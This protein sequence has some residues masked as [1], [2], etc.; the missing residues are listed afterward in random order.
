MQEQQNQPLLQESSRRN[1][2]IFPNPIQ[3]PIVTNGKK[4]SVDEY[5][6]KDLQMTQGVIQHGGFVPGY[7][8]WANRDESQ[9]SGTAKR[10][11][12]EDRVD[13][14]LYIQSQR[15]K[16]ESVLHGL[17]STELSFTTLN[18]IC[19]SAPLA[20]T[21]PSLRIPS[22]ASARS[23]S[24]VEGSIASQRSSPV[25]FGDGYELN[26]RSA[27]FSTERHPLSPVVQQIVF[28]VNDTRV[29]VVQHAGFHPHFAHLQQMESATASLRVNEDYNELCGLC[30]VQRA[31]VPMGGCEHRIC[32]V[33]YRHEKHRSLR[34]F[35]DA[36]PSCPFCAHGVAPTTSTTRVSDN[37][38]NIPSGADSLRQQRHFSLP[39]L[40]QQSCASQQSQHQFGDNLQKS[41]CQGR[42]SFDNS[43]A[44]EVGDGNCYNRQLCQTF[45][46][47]GVSPNAMRLRNPLGQLEN[48]SA[49][50]H[51]ES[52]DNGNMALGGGT[53]YLSHIFQVPPQGSY[54]KLPPG[55]FSAQA[56]V[57]GPNIQWQLRSYQQH[58]LRP[59]GMNQHAP[60]FHPAGMPGA[61]QANNSNFAATGRPGTSNSPSIW[62]EGLVSPDSS[63]QGSM[64]FQQQKMQT[65]IQH[66]Q[67]QQRRAGHHHIFQSSIGLSGH[68]GNSYYSEG[69]NS[70]D[71]NGMNM[72]TSETL[73]FPILPN[74]PPAIPPPTP[75]TEVIK[76]AVVRVTNIPW[77]VSLHDML[78]FFS[79][80]PYPPEHLLPQNVHILMDRA[81]GKTYHSAF[82]ELALSNHQAGMVAQ[83]RNM[84]VLKGRVVTVELSS[85]DELMRSIFPKWAGEFAYGEPMM[86]GENP[87]PSKTV[88][89]NAESNQE[90]T[91]DRA[92]DGDEGIKEA[93]IKAFDGMQDQGLNS[94]PSALQH[95]GRSVLSTGSHG[96]GLST[97]GPVDSISGA[98]E[99][100]TLRFTPPFVARDEI[101]ALLAICR[102][103]KLHF[104]RKCAER[105]FENILSILAKYPW[106]LPHRILPL[107]RD[108]IFELLKLSI[109]SLRT[110]LSKDYNTIN[111][112]LLNRMVRSAIL[113]PA[114]TE[115]QKLMVLHV[116]SCQCPDDIVGWMAPPAPV[117]V[118][119]D[120]AAHEIESGSS[121]AVEA[122]EEDLE[123]KALL[124]ES[125]SQP[126]V[127]T[128][129]LVEDLAISTENA[130]KSTLDVATRLERDEQERFPLSI[131]PTASSSKSSGPPTPSPDNVE[132]KEPKSNATVSWASI[133]TPAVTGLAAT[134]LL[135]VNTTAAAAT[136][137]NTGAMVDAEAHHLTLAP[138]YAAAVVQNAS[139]L[140]NYKEF[141]TMKTPP[142]SGR[143]SDDVMLPRS[144]NCISKH[145]NGPQHRHPSPSF[146]ISKLSSFTPPNTEYPDEEASIRS[147]KF[148]GNS[149]DKLNSPT[150]QRKPEDLGAGPRQQPNVTNDTA[151]SDTRSDNGM[152]SHYRMQKNTLPRGGRHSKL[153]TDSPSETSSKTSTTNNGSPLPSLQLSPISS[154]TTVVSSSDMASS[155]PRVDAEEK[156]KSETILDAIKTI[157]QSTPRLPKPSSLNYMNGLT[158]ESPL[159]STALGHQRREGG[160]TL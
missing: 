99:V 79:G 134:R 9:S 137:P 12:G 38:P 21:N 10:E 96:E 115:K 16:S 112:T 22:V 147:E 27:S 83:A 148:K 92:V 71:C 24:P 65:Q 18:S 19:Q 94:K 74:L 76:W 102:N 86:P 98:F 61:Q 4:M 100:P 155:L 150:E 159:C 62:H 35:Q 128:E 138:S 72:N 156:S 47:H 45:S 111:P 15:R 141:L 5:H 31:T 75:R 41:S 151:T 28:G 84:K 64:R 33:C 23:T 132:D 114:F 160:E 11:T 130:T 103:Y 57:A 127:E 104:S 87:L 133:A 46:G 142:I 139:N 118:G 108:H 67:S 95:M 60:S 120:S 42:G 93:G 110:H 1:S 158:L 80:I 49:S 105:P 14:R 36:S 109:E 121:V 117:E 53:R 43:A 51:C 136:L 153:E 81:T 50:Q 77:E 85:Q 40:Y 20:F 56:P 144:S 26:L 52:G 125:E 69:G 101:N 129:D 97:R 8:I 89:E 54:Q 13:S 37:L 91:F 123:E 145:R 126:H 55:R 149:I 25:F 106:H 73:L 107:H 78:S 70:N 143:T 7:D 154:A 17:A 146:S 124:S 32:N 63:S 122:T 119:S 39:Q 157:T 152:D 140:S 113:T 3:P 2:R 82:V 6:V 68:A 88:D 66:Q 48:A 44:E 34:L 131:Y 58:T 90:N 116:A 59:S 29:P 30:G 135:D